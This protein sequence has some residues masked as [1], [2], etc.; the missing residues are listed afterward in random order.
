[1][2]VWPRFVTFNSDRSRR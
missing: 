1:M 2:M